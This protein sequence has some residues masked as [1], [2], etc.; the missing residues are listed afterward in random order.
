MP[1]YRCPGA[2]ESPESVRFSIRL[3]CVHDVREG[4]FHRYRDVLHPSW[5]VK[6]D[7]GPVGRDTELAELW[8]FLSAAS[9]APAAVAITGDAGIGK[10]MVWQRVVQSACR[11]SRVLSCQ[12][13]S[14][15]RTLA[16]SALHDLFGDVG[17]DVLETLEGPMRRA[18][19]VML[20]RAPSV[21]PP[22]AGQPEANRP[23]Q[24]QRAL[25]RGIL[26]ILRIL[27]DSA[28]LMLAVDDAQW[29]DQPSARVL[30]FCFRRL[31]RGAHLDLADLP[32]G[33]HWSSRSAW[34]G[35][36]RRTV[37]CVCRWARSA[38]ALSA[39]SYGHGWGLC[40]P[41]TPS[42]GCTRRAAETLSMPSRSPARFS[43]TRACPAPMSRSRSRRVSV[44]SCSGA[45]AS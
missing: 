43:S 41:G 45:C 19:E 39:R 3:R 27:S 10:T 42:R 13:A 21:S 40:C 18:V 20:L 12:A 4:G 11:S 8:A 1:R 34:T 29:L 25:A 15:E 37:L 26:S 5:G 2:R 32:L 30:E 35:P 38:W 6:V 14:A 24:Q 31:E 36:C 28:P 17:G 9:G 44:V 23:R 33:Q 16:F 22:P 7:L